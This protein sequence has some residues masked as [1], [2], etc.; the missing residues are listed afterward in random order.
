V[1]SVHAAPQGTRVLASI[2]TSALESQAAFSLLGEE[3]RVA[4]GGAPKL[5]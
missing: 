4:F 1:S 3:L 2:L 5:S